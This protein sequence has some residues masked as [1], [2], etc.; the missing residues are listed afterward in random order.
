MANFK[1]D[2]QAIKTI[3]NPLSGEVHIPTRGRRIGDNQPSLRDGEAGSTLFEDHALRDKIIRFDHGRI[4]ESEINTNAAAAHGV[5]TV[6]ESQ[7]EFTKA[8]FLQNPG[9]TTPV[10]VRFSNLVGARGSVDCARDP[11]GFA[12][13]FY[14]EEGNFDLVGSNVP[15]FYIQDTSTLNDLIQAVKSE[16]NN[17]IPN[18]SATHNTP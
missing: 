4:P 16:P 14:T 17:Q 11:R 13:R 1:G 3:T 12:V 15:V 8:L 10:F 2:T 9:T 18:V 6:Y 7:C 5:F